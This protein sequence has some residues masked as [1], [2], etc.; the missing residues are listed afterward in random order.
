MVFLFRSFRHGC[1]DE[2]SNDRC[3]SGNNSDDQI[4]N[5]DVQIIHL[6]LGA[7][8]AQDEENVHDKVVEISVFIG[9]LYDCVR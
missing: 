7:T 8:I 6:L 4:R 9:Q 2:N 5:I 1:A 3:D